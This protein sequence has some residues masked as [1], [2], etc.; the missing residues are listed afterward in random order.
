M[1]Y[2]DEERQSSSVPKSDSPYKQPIL[3]FMQVKKQKTTKQR[4]AKD[5]NGNEEQD[6]SKLYHSP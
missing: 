3:N 2:I 5:D 4:R 6:L 1:H